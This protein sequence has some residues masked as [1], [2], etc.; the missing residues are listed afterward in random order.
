MVRVWRLPGTNSLAREAGKDKIT[1]ERLNAPCYNCVL[2]GIDLHKYMSDPA[3]FLSPWLQQRSQT[4]T[5]H[6]VYQPQVPGPPL[7]LP[8]ISLVTQPP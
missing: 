8:S 3:L 4:Y 5:V 1:Y 2:E 6:N 7:T